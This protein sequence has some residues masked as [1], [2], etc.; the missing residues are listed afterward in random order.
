MVKAEV[1]MRDGRILIVT[2]RS[3]TGLANKLEKLGGEVK[4]FTARRVKIDQLRQ[5]KETSV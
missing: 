1:E 2:A 4:G 3:F 5:G